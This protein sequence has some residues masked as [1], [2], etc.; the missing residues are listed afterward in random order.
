MSDTFEEGTSVYLTLGNP[1]LTSSK[2]KDGAKYKVT[3]EIP[4][5][6]FLGMM[7]ADITGL[8]LEAQCLVAHAPSQAPEKPQA[9]RSKGSGKDRP[10]PHLKGGPLSKN[11]GRLCNDED[12]WVYLRAEQADYL[13]LIA[14]QGAPMKDCCRQFILDTLQ[15]E[16]LRQLDAGEGMATEY[17]RL[18]S[19]PFIRYRDH[20]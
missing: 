6:E 17:Q 18:I 2:T 9:G 1:R 15:I 3:F 20:C 7:H 5:D 8:V 10:Y 12:F 11:A 4:E 13:E 19:S 14:D 16:T